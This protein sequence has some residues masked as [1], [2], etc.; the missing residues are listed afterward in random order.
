MGVSRRLLTYTRRPAGIIKPNRYRCYA[1]VNQRDSHPG[2]TQQICGGRAGRC[3]RSAGGRDK[4]DGR[5][6]GHSLSVGLVLRYIPL[7]TKTKLE[8]NMLYNQKQKKLGDIL[9]DDLI[10]IVADERLAPDEN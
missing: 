7:T 4:G 3:G 6:V 9:Q 1:F 2:R 8:I 5:A 10:S